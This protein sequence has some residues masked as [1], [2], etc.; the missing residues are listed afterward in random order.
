LI[1]GETQQAIRFAAPTP[2]TATA[3]HIT[4]FV[5]VIGWLVSLMTG[6]VGGLVTYWCTRNQRRRDAT[7]RD[8]RAAQDALL[9]LRRAYRERAG[10]PKAKTDEELAAL[11]DSLDI[12]CDRTFSDV[13]MRQGRAYAEVGGLYAAQDPDTGVAAEKVAYDSLARALI[14]EL[15]RS[16]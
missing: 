5:L 12:A 4:P 9:D 2:D 13:V 3:V 14:A 11:S 1:L 8:A 16:R 7:D 10:N 15:K 6:A